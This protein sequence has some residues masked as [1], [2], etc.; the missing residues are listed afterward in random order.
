MVPSAVVNVVHLSPALPG[1]VGTCAGG[2]LDG[3]GAAGALGAIAEV[4]AGPEAEAVGCW[5]PNCGAHAARKRATGTRAAT[6]LRT[7]P[8]L[9]L[10][11]TP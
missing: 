2:T 3:V 11:L 4:L 10:T 9:G 5:L 7:T 8:S 6:N 1:A